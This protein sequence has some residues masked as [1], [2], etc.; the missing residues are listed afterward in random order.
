MTMM[1][2]KY[3][4]ET[5]M[6]E[7]DSAIGSKTKWKKTKDVI[8]QSMKKMKKNEEKKICGRIN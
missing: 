3:G 5:K 1:Q 2:I 8:M 7:R 4:S 6:I